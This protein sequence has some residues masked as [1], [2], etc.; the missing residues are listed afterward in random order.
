MAE[1]AEQVAREI[2]DRLEHAW[3]GADADTWADQFAEDADFVT[4]RGDY[5]RG[6]A[7]IAGGH[8]AIFSTIYKGSQNH[9]ELLRTRTLGETV[10][11]AHARAWLS[12]PA[13]P[14]A[15]QHQAVMSLTLVPSDGRW[16][17]VSFHNTF[18]PAQP[19]GQEAGLDRW[20][21]HAAD[22]S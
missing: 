17:I 22:R 4:V 6:R 21:D 10:I 19:F 16:R 1:Q 12:V 20:Q 3:N 8:H 11:V 15:G 5:F 7:D 14:M 9:L 18:R 2:L 13:G